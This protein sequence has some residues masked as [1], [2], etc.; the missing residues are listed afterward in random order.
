MTYLEVELNFMSFRCIGESIERLLRCG[1]EI[2]DNTDDFVNRRLIDQTARSINE[3]T[4]VFVKFNLRWKLHRL[5]TG[6]PRCLVA[7]SAR[8]FSQPFQRNTEP[9]RGVFSLLKYS[10]PDRRV[11]S[12][13]GM[14]LA[15][16]DNRGVGRQNRRFHR[17]TI[18]VGETLDGEKSE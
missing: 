13:Y 2:F 17:R 6:D 4:N 8:T 12:D 1:F 11:L 7:R 3:Q 9:F 15:I 5:L 10:D 16:M 14:Q 18:R